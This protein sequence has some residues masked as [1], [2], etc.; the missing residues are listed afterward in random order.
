MA[1][2][3][4]FVCAVF[5]AFASISVYTALNGEKLMSEQWTGNTMEE[6]NGRLIWGTIPAYA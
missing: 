2:F 4:F 5:N 3:Y 1:R 6:S